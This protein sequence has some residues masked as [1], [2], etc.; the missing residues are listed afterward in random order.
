MK[1]FFYAF[2]IAII[3]LSTTSCE[4]D[5]ESSKS[6]KA[7]YSYAVSEWHASSTSVD[8][9]YRVIN[10][11]KSEFAKIPNASLR[12]SNKIEMEGNFG[13]CDN[14]VL[15]ACRAAEKNAYINKGT[16]TISVE[17]AHIGGGFNKNFYSKTYKGKDQ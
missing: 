16:L 9:Y 3:A 17:S 4:L 6:G 11:Y 7:I 15:N 1:K 13:V 14:A 2:A 12:E 5:D 8:D 10:A